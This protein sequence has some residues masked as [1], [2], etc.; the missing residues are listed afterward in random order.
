MYTKGSLLWRIFGLKDLND[1]KD[2]DTSKVP[3]DWKNFINYN[4]IYNL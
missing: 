4:D 1:T 2:D 3:N